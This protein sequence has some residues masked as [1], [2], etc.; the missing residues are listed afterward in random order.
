MVMMMTFHCVKLKRK[1]WKTFLGRQ[2]RMKKGKVLKLLFIFF[3]LKSVIFFLLS[4]EEAGNSSQLWSIIVQAQPRL[5]QNVNKEFS[6]F[7]KEKIFFIQHTCCDDIVVATTH[8]C[9]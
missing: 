9:I 2:W 4:I 5:P 6:I 8:G 7:T 3:S 1:F